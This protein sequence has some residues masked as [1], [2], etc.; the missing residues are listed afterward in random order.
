MPS[1]EVK[2]D[3]S[4]NIERKCNTNSLVIQFKTN[5]DKK[6]NKT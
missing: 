3:L 5:L 1:E 2:T 4:V 6:A